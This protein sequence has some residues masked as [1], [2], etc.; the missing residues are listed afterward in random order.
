VTA[1]MGNERA[2]RVASRATGTGVG[3]IAFM[4]AWT[5]GARVTE[6]LWG[7]PASAYVALAVAVLTGII[8]AHRAGRRLAAAGRSHA[9]GSHGAS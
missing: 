3:L 8:V 2:D 4:I 7:P 6:H 1:R 5:V 9:G